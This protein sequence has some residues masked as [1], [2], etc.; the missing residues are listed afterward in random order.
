MTKKKKNLGD[1]GYW[2]EN[3]NAQNAGLGATEGVLRAAVFV[4]K[5]KINEQR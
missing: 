1:S 5:K 3:L 2:E 4:K